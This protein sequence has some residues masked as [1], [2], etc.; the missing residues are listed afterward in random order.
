[1]EPTVKVV[2]KSI[3][4]WF[5]ANFDEETVATEI[6]EQENLGWQLISSYGIS[7]RT[8]MSFQGITNALVFIYRKK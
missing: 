7:T 8:V 6:Q 1:M 5:S 2:K 4:G 3:K